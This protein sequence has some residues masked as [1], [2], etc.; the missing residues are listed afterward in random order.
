MGIAPRLPVARQLALGCLMA[1]LGFWLMRSADH[2]GALA[3]AGVVNGFGAGLLL[4]T[5]VTWCMRV[6]PF[7]RRGL[8]TGAFQ[9]CLFLG[10]FVNPV[11]V[12]SLERLHGGSRAAGIGAI[13]MA[14]M[15]LAVVALLA[16]TRTR[17]A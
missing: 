4:P 7:V 15:A 6:L 8:G 1:G 9:S 13:G 2:Y 3:A 11:L 14:L 10:M 17:K 16:S 5:M 12:V